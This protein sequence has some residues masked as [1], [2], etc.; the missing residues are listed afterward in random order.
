MIKALKRRPIALLWSGQ[1]LSSVGDEIYRVA[2]VWLAVGLIGARAGYLSAAQLGSL[3]LLSVVG[4]HWADQWDHRRTM[5]GVD[6]LRGLIVLLPVAARRFGGLGLPLLAGVAVAVAALSAFFDPALQATIPEVSDDER[7]RQ[8][9]TALMGSTSR[10][11]RAVGPGIIAAL[12]AFVP[13]IHFFTLDSLSFFVS[14][15]SIKLLPPRRTPPSRPERAAFAKSLIAGWRAIAGDRRLRDLSLTRASVAAL[16]YLAFALGLALMVQKLSPGDLG[17]FGSVV[18]AYGA[19]NVLG[20]VYIGHV[21][22]DRPWRFA[23]G[24]YLWLGAGF[25]LMGLAPTLG[26]L[27]VASFFAAIGG[28]V[29]DIPYYDLVQRDYPGVELTRILRFSR[30]CETGASLLVMAA[31]PT[32]MSYFSPGLVVALC[33]LSFAVLGAAGLW[34]TRDGP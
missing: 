20:A 21:R 9:A 16:W 12:S 17:A 3:F 33:G 10:L 11:A 15:L 5:I 30:S 14:A 32:L 34:S 4:G 7:T 6:A 25:L 18:A 24:G 31:S 27:R 28:P 1:A 29:N 13:M 22:R 8:A 23:Y 19:G 2:L 26:W